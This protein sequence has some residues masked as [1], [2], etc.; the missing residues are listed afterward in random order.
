MGLALLA[1]HDG[2]RIQERA[3]QELTKA[4][5]KGDAWWKVIEEEKVEYITAFVKEVLR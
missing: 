3:Y 5:P 4:Y 2:Q 1:S